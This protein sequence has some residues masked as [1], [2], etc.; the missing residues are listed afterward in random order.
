MGGADPALVTQ[1]KA[2]A[3]PGAAA[4][5]VQ[6]V[7]AGL[8]EVSRVE[9]EECDRVSASGTS[10][11]DNEEVG[12]LEEQQGLSSS[13]A[14]VVGK[15]LADQVFVEMPQSVQ[16]SAGRVLGGTSSL[17]T[18]SRSPAGASLVLE[19]GEHRGKVKMVGE[20][21]V[22]AQGVQNL[23]VPS[24]VAAVDV[25]QVDA[26]DD[27][28]SSF[29]SESCERVSTSGGSDSDCEE[30][31]VLVVEQQGLCSTQPEKTRV[32]MTHQVLD[33]MSQS[34]LAAAGAC[35]GGAS[36]LS[37]MELAGGVPLGGTKNVGAGH[38]SGVTQ[39]MDPHSS[40]GVHG[41]KV[42][43]GEPV[44]AQVG[45][46]G[47]AQVAPWVNLFRDN[48]NL[49]KG[50]MLE[51]LEVEGDRV[52]L[53]KDDVDVVEEAWGF[54]LVG[55]FA[56]KFPGMVAVSKLRESWKVK[57]SFWRHR[58]G[59]LVFKFQSDEDRLKV[60]NGGPYF[61]YGSNLMLK[62]MPSCFRFEGE[63][64]TSVPIWIQLPGLPLDCWNGRALSKIV[65]KVGKPISS[66]KMTLTKERISFAR[67][68]VE[69]D[70]SSDIVSEVEIQLPTGVVYHQSVIPEFTPKFCQRCKTF[71]HVEATCGKG[72]EGG[73]QPAFVAKKK[74]LSSGAGKSVP[75]A[76]SS[77]VLPV[78]RPVGMPRFGVGTGGEGSGDVQ[79]VAVPGVSLPR[80]A[81]ACT[82][83]GL[84]AV[85]KGKHIL[86]PAL[87]VTAG[88]THHPVVEGLGLGPVC[89]AEPVATGDLAGPSGADL[90][91][92]TVVQG[93]T[94]SGKKGKK[95]KKSGQQD[96]TSEHQL[97]EGEGLLLEPGPYDG[98]VDCFE[99]WN[100][101]GKKGRRKV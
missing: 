91:P 39:G 67:V 90:L 77:A 5:R 74:T 40:P 13:L 72:S 16:S 49:S 4:V 9:S 34:D 12:L 96:V 98:M 23:S 92:R 20:G 84:A 1:K 79:S 17:G 2:V 26:E 54:C 71:G 95:K 50:L 11:S 57:C 60:L 64:V 80:P 41:E 8:V 18:S 30:E 62:I 33:V 37:E 43:G 78:A 85:N 22:S 66:D 25:Q 94:G 46:V 51:E 32:R 44:I 48:R 31:G 3:K 28:V 68:L 10:E 97:S 47:D 59:W 89:Q 101:G 73:Q 53:E 35:F 83:E 38:A 69:V 27:K 70:V 7:A 99:G 58:S 21:S 6:R 76:P 87:Q 86:G 61:A 56:G 52:L 36:S 88:S 82:E 29:D 75:F 42:G 63:A 93:A 15:E 55:L 100:K 45:A 65:S 19:G 81:V 14:N 24:H